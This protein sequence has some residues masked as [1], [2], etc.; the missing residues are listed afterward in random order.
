MYFFLFVMVY[1]CGVLWFFLFC[2]FKDAVSKY[3]EVTNNLEFAKELQRSFMA[4]SQDVSKEQAVQCGLSKHLS[5]KLFFTDTRCSSH[6][7]LEGWNGHGFL[8]VWLFFCTLCTALCQ[9]FWRLFLEEFSDELHK[10]MGTKIMWSFSDKT[11]LLE[12]SVITKQ[13][14]H[15]TL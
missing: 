4:L 14:C 6:L 9:V 5:F 15:A 1:F 7:S 13:A 2:F 10:R 3:Q 12:N 11:E 8:Y